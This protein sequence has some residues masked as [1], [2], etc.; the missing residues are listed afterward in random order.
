ME[1][2]GVGVSGEEALGLGLVGHLS[3]I[4]NII[5][6]SSHTFIALSHTAES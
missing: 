6:E 2:A 5:E 1:L 4:E 3:I